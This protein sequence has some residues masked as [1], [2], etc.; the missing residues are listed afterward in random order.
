MKIR[1]GDHHYED[2]SENQRS[3]FER[4]GLICVRRANKKIVDIRTVNF[5]NRRAG[6]NKPTALAVTWS[7][8]ANFPVAKLLSDHAP[9]LHHSNHLRQPMRR[10][11]RLLST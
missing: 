3:N 11:K 6:W 8:A 5:I 1:A 4:E 7:H 10:D 9:P 2:Q